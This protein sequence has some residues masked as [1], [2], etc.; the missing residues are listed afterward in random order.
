MP[1]KAKQ[2]LLK[3]NIQNFKIYPIARPYRSIVLNV[4]KI[5]S[6]FA[7]IAMDKELLDNTINAMSQLN[8]AI[9][10]GNRLNGKKVDSFIT[11]DFRLIF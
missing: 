6:R 9:V 5:P 1:A 8:K 11:K 10:G 7:R 2:D 4:K 3:D